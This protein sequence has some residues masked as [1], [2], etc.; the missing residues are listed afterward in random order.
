MSERDPNGRDP[1]QPG[2]KLDAGKS[3]VWLCVSGFARALE[4]VANVTTQGAKK[5][6]PDGWM[7]VQ[8][9][10]SRYMDALGRHL[11]KLGTGEKNDADTGCH[12][13][14]QVAWNALAALELEL[15]RDEAELAESAALVSQA[16]QAPTLHPA[17]VQG[18][19]IR[20]TYH[21]IKDF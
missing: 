8:D 11:L 13:L 16:I 9:G 6:T 3:R 4:Q 5:Y 19:S 7:T 2:A 17:T 14:A 21:V 18:S 10:E 12:H 1:H 15:R 20:P